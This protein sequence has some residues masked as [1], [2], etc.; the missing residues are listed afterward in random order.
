MTSEKQK[1]KKGAHMHGEESH[2][3]KNKKTKT[4]EKNPTTKHEQAVKAKVDK[5]Q[6]KKEKREGVVI[7][8][9]DK[10]MIYRSKI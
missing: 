2:E 5:R 6:A 4:G 1:T 7:T 3:T 8:E 10:Q 9:V